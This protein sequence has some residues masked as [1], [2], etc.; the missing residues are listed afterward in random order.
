M[1]DG[2]DS[3]PDGTGKPAPLALDVEDGGEAAFPPAFFE[4]GAEMTVEA[5]EDL[6]GFGIEFVALWQ[7]RD[8]EKAAAAAEKAKLKADRIQRLR[9]SVVRWAELYPE[10]AA[11][12]FNALL[13][14]DPAVYVGDT[15]KQFGA[16]FAAG[17]KLRQNTVQTPAKNGA[18][19]A[20]AANSLEAA[21]A[22]TKAGQTTVSAAGFPIPPSRPISED[23]SV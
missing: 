4:A 5:A 3:S 22:A 18:A 19:T 21:M 7:L 2:S 12:L 1:G 20:P 10:R 23:F 6:K 11:K 8:A 15:V 13:Y 9:A 16:I 14:W 17:A